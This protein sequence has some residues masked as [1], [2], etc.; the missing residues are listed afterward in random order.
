M[1]TIEE[2]KEKLRKEKLSLE[3][4]MIDNVKTTFGLKENLEN[5]YL[6]ENISSTLYYLENK[7]N[8]RDDYN[9]YFESITDLVMEYMQVQDSEIMEKAM[10]AN[11]RRR[12][13][14]RELNMYRRFFVAKEEHKHIKLFMK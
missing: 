10:D 14:K 8:G 11:I 2:F 9:F 6:L 1:K 7:H 4:N 13:I 12:A 5:N 3:K